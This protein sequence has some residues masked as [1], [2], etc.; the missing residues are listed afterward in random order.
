MILV[1]TSVIADIFT[2]APDWFAWSSAQIEQ[3]ADQG[4]VAYDAIIFA[5]LAV[6]FDTSL[7]SLPI[8]SGWGS[9]P[10]AG[11]APGSKPPIRRCLK[12]AVSL[13]SQFGCIGTTICPRISTRFTMSSFP[14]N[15]PAMPYDSDGDLSRLGVG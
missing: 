6:K 7:I 8:L 15:L 1:D 13:A 10:N 2:R 5:E 12:S 14:I 4:P 11:S 9:R 3:A